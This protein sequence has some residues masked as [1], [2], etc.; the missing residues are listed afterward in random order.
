MTRRGALHISIDV[1][2]VIWNGNRLKTHVMYASNLSITTLNKYI[3]NLIK[4]GYVTKT[5]NQYFT[6]HKGLKILNA[7]RDIIKELP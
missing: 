3:N 7:T 5:D 6:T 4:Y 1:M 2:R